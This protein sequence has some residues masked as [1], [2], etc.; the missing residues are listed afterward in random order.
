MIPKLFSDKFLQLANDRGVTIP[1]MLGLHQSTIVFYPFITSKGL[2]NI[3]TVFNQTKEEDDEL[4]AYYGCYINDEMS[5]MEKAR[6]IANKVNERLYYVHDF[7]QYKRAEY[8]AKPIEVHRNKRDDCD[9]YAVLICYLLRLF[10]AKDYEVFVCT[11]Y[12]I[13][14][15]GHAYVLVLDINTFMFYP[16]EGSYYAERTLK[17]FGQLPHAYN[18]RYKKVWWMTNDSKSYS[19]IPWLRFVR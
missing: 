19:K 15:E 1:Q 6:V 11:G 2:R 14:G 5:T 7:T 16:L 3:K 10:G 18:G 9:G 17:E 13:S 12:V 4:I 8:W